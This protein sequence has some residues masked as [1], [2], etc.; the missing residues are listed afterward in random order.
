MD[1]STKAVRKRPR[2]R[3]ESKQTQAGECLLE[4]K[5]EGD[6]RSAMRAT[7]DPT[8]WRQK[9]AASETGENPPSR[10]RPPPACMTPALPPAPRRLAPPRPSREER[11]GSAMLNH[12]QRLPPPDDPPPPPLPSADHPRP[13]PPACRL[14]SRRV[15]LSPVAFMAA[16]RWVLAV[17]FDVSELGWAGCCAARSEMA[18][19]QTLTPTQHRL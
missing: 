18:A 14:S 2:P 10:P 4:R 12:I 5:G 19:Q 3:Q 16:A 6:V 7:H 9:E 1:S 11:K 17:L 15:A 8:V 13:P